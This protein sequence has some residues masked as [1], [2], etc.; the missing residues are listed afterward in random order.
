MSVRS[1]GCLCGAVRIEVSGE[2][3]SQGICRCRA[4]QRN[5]GG[6]PANILIYPADA[7]ELKQGEL[8][9]YD[10]PGDSGAH[11]SRG[12][13]PNCGAPVMSSLSST[14]AITIVKLGA[15][16]DPSFFKPEVIY[17]TSAA[18]PWA[19]HPEGV[20]QFTHN[21]PAGG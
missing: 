13:C 18:Q 19:V 15:L 9:Y 11:V 4:C 17:W 21:P 7:V 5:C 8:S 20:P 14:D 3:I 16:D 6:Q 12:F 1:G 10:T 2:P